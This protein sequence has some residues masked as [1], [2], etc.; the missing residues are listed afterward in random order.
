MSLFRGALPLHTRDPDSAGGSPRQAAC[1]VSGVGGCKLPACWI[2]KTWCPALVV[3]CRARGA[4]GTGG[5][6]RGRCLEGEKEKDQGDG[7]RGDGER[8]GRGR[9][10]PPA[11]AGDSSARRSPA[12]VTWRKPL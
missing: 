12:L 2:G 1:M 6:Q 4:R 3:G 10:K 5:D 8:Q 9:G 7:R 11:R